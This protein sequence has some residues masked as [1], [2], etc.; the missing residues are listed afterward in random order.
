MAY[1]KNYAP[2]NRAEVAGANDHLWIPEPQKWPVDKA[3]FNKTYNQ[4][5]GEKPLNIWPRD[6]N[7]KL[8]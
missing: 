6:K 3:K 5:F 4:L 1:K 7:G 2:K 8:I